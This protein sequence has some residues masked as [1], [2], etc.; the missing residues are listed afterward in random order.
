M[1]KQKTLECF[2]KEVYDI[3]GKEYEVLDE[4]KN[5]KTKILIKHNCGHEFLSI[6]K[7]LLRKKG[8]CPKCKRKNLTKENLLD[9]IPEGYTYLSGFKSYKDKC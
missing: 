9:E 2:K 8:G 3:Y 6:P 1:G 4:Y 5:N 7:D